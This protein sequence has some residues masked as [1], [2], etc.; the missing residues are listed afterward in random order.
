VANLLTAIR[1]VAA[2]PFGS[3]MAAGTERAAILAALVFLMA[4]ATDLLD[5]HVAR[6]TGSA[7]PLGG[8]FDHTTDFLFVMCGLIG[9]VSRGAFPWLLPFVIAV[10]FTEYVVGSYWI[11]GQRQL[12]GSRLGRY[13]GILYFVPLAGE[14]LVGLGWTFL[15]P[16]VRGVAWLLVLSTAISIGQRLNALRSLR[17]ERR[18]PAD[19]TPLSR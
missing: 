13:N 17:L 6:R 12:R 5:G 2:L 14:I 11:H 9:G 10:A 7:S 19:E 15:R 18:A 4:I 1:L 3:L 8:T 16:V